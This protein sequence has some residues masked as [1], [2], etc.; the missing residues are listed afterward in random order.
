MIYQSDR[1]GSAVECWIVL[2]RNV[3]SNS[4]R[5]RK[6]LYASF[7]ASSCLLVASAL[8]SIRAPEGP[9]ESIHPW[10]TSTRYKWPDYAQGSRA[11]CGASAREGHSGCPFLL[12]APVCYQS[13]RISVGTVCAEAGREAISSGFEPAKALVR[14]LPLPRPSSFR[15]HLGCLPVLWPIRGV[16]H[17][18]CMGEH[19]ATSDR[20]VAKG[21]KGG[22]HEWG[23]G[24]ASC[25]AY[26]QQIRG[27][28]AL[29]RLH[30]VPMAKPIAVGPFCHPLRGF[31]EA[32]ETPVD[33]GQTLFGN[34]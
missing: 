22:R 28:A 8:I 21:G 2:P 14:G 24:R 10:A 32:T 27:P 5:K 16:G 19:G 30:V 23:G 33:L 1:V 12:G 4:R 20:L 26:S 13:P 15:D 6:R 3:H 31:A 7:K 9:F 17:P 18:W 29:L 34:L 25:S 11:K